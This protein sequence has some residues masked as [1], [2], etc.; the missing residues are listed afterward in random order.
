[1]RTRV[2]PVVLVALVVAPIAHAAFPPSDGSA[3]ALLSGDRTLAP[4]R[5][6]AEAMG[7]TVRYSAGV[8]TIGNADTAIRLTIGSRQ[9]LVGKRTALLD[10]P[11]MVISGVSY[12]PVRFVA[13]TFGARVECPAPCRQVTVRSDGDELVLQVAVDRGDWLIYRGPWFDIEY[14]RSFRPLA[15]DRAPGAVNVKTFDR[16][17]I[18]FGSP[19]GAVEF[20]V[21]SPQWS[22]DPS[23]VRPAPGER[24]IER[25]VSTEGAGPERK[26][27]TWVTIAGPGNAWKRSYVQIRQPDLNTEWYFGFRYQDAAAYAAYRPAYLHFRSSLVQ[28]AD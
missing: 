17:G 10:V 24:E 19:E 5:F 12:V 1:M 6:L 26:L 7:A 15:F 8:I 11:P 22:G 4:L 27:L 25:S 3:V 13:E 16:D 21:Y 9:A 18:S 14:P 2:L 28:Y 23:W 20:Y